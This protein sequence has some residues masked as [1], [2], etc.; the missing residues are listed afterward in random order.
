MILPKGVSARV[1]RTGNLVMRIHYSADPDRGA[2]WAK[3]ER[4]KY[5]S[6]GAWD[7][8]QE[9]IHEAGGGERLFSEALDR[10][11]DSI[12]IDP[13]TSGFRPSPHWR[14]IGGFDH[15]K[16]N[17][18]AALVAAVDF[19]GVIYILGEYYQPG[20]SP[21]QHVPAL[22][23]MSAFMRAEVFAD[24]SIFYK[25]QAQADGRFKAISELY[26]EE[27]LRICNRRRRT[28]NCWA[29]NASSPTGPISSIASP[30]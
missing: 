15:G 3:S 6:Q 16:A 2:E 22:Q 19:D 21:R 23:G 5:S 24:P 18:T 27:A 28:T 8:E 20:L 29:W 17:P 7:R 10:W 11:E 25:T 30:P 4:R 14:I 26:A 13:Y 9:I 1:T 12:V